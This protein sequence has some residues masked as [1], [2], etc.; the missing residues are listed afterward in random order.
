MWI[1]TMEIKLDRN[2]IKADQQPFL[3]PRRF[4]MLT[5]NKMQQYEN[6]LFHDFMNK[7]WIWFTDNNIEK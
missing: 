6:L 3:L 7:L 1:Y 4:E 2:K 5:V